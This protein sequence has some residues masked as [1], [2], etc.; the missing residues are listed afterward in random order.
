MLCVCISILLLTSHRHPCCYGKHFLLYLCIFLKVNISEQEA[1]SSLAM[2]MMPVAKQMRDEE[3]LR[4]RMSQD[5]VIKSRRPNGDCAC[6]LMCR[7]KTIHALK[8]SGHFLSREKLHEEVSD[9]EV[10]LMRQAIAGEQQQ[11]VLEKGNA[12]WKMDI[13]TDINE[14]IMERYHISLTWLNIKR[15]QFPLNPDDK[16]ITA[17]ATS[18][19]TDEFTPGWLN[20]EVITYGVSCQSYLLIDRHD[21]SNMNVFLF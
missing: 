4:R 6:E 20:D 5:H 7:W 3:A 15:L 2:N 10:A 14:K 8:A 17:E 13:N 11:Q 21:E 1:A 9:A 18:S 16:R 19:R 12:K